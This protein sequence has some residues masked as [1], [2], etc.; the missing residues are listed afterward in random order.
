[1]SRIRNSRNFSLE[2]DDYIRNN[3]RDLFDDE[4]A[5]HLRRPEGSITRRRQRLGCWHV[6]QEVFGVIPGEQW[7]SLGIAGDHYQ[8]SNMGRVKAG[9]KLSSLFIAKYGYVQL[10][11]VNLSKGIAETLKIHRAVAEHFCV[12][13]ENWD[14][15]WHVHHLDKN[16][17]N[18]S[19][20]NLQWMSPE[21]HRAEHSQLM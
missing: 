19:S 14:E 11:I 20:E 1:M 18:N 6:Q 7:A 2:E 13:P 16:P 9:R 15:S 10:R 8:I 5:I 3:F 4:L 21:D 17:Q 12:K